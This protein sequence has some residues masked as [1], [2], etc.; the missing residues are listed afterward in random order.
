LTDEAAVVD[1]SGSLLSAVWSAT[2]LRLK[3]CVGVPASE[4]SAL[5]IT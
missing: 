2:M 5:L 3:T 4:P 1:G